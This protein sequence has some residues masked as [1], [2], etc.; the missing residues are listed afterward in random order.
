M[1]TRLGFVEERVLRWGFA[2][3]VLAAVWLV[4]DGRGETDIAG[5]LA[6]AKAARGLIARR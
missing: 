6:V 5:V 4:Q 1:C 3:A 2:Q